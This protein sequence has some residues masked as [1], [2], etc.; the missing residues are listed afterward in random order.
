MKIEMTEE[1]LFTV[2][3]PC[4]SRV[5]SCVSCC[6]ERRLML[7]YRTKSAK[8]LVHR[9]LQPIDLPRIVQS[10]RMKAFRP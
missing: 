4:V 1:L 9:S 8:E 10:R 2:T 7:Q 6:G 5:P 3:R